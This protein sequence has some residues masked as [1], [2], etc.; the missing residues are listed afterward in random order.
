M[1]EKPGYQLCTSVNEGITEITI[2]GEITENAVDKLKD[3]V[4]AILKSTRIRNVVVDVRDIKG[5]FGPIEA[6]FR[7]R[8]Y[9]T[10]T[11]P[12]NTAIVDLPENAEFES[13]HE[14]TG[15][16]AGLSMKWFTD[17]NDARTWLKSK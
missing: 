2:K 10:D 14:T 17:I 1:D 6:Y 11:P 12:V 16:N 5:R 8:S 7:V 13:F 15:R 9:P 3:D 4:L